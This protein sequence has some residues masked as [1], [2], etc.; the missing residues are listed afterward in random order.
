MTSSL[1]R[2][3]CVTGAASEIGLATAYRLAELG[4]RWSASM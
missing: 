2:V 3:A 4:L 1:D